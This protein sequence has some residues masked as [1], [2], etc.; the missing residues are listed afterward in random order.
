MRS[1]IQTA[2]GRV[3]L[4]RRADVA[5]RI[6]AAGLVAHADADVGSS[7][8]LLSA[9][10]ALFGLRNG[11]LMLYAKPLT[12]LISDP[13]TKTSYKW[14]PA[15]GVAEL[16]TKELASGN[17][18]LRD[19]KCPMSPMRFNGAQPSGSPKAAAIGSICLCSPGRA[20]CR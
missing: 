15:V 3:S 11:V 8:K 1:G 5:N 13:N 7:G 10:H 16:A 2:A 18:T 14:Q 6:I 19:S 4:Y 17:L 9:T 12:F 20:T